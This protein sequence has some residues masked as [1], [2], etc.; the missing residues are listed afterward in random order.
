MFYLADYR[1]SM[2]KNAQKPQLLLLPATARVGGGGGAVAAP[3]RLACVHSTGTQLQLTGF[4]RQDQ[5][6]AVVCLF[7]YLSTTMIGKVGFYRTRVQTVHCMHSNTQ[8]TP[9]FRARFSLPRCSCLVCVCD[10]VQCGNTARVPALLSGPSLLL[11]THMGGYFSN[12][13]ILRKFN[14]E[15]KSEN[16]TKHRRRKKGFQCVQVTKI[17]KS[18]FMLTKIITETKIFLQNLA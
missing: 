8:T 14:H 15:Q 18:I 3:S 11:F 6:C 1:G 7:I 16:K 2:E 17:E 12:L 5:P 9:I 10:H 13:H 4:P